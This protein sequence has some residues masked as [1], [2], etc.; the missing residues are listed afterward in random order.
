MISNHIEDAIQA[1]PQAPQI[2]AARQADVLANAFDV[3]KSSPP[4]TA[5][6]ATADYI[7]SHAFW[8]AHQMPKIPMVPH[9][10]PFL[11]GLPA[12]STGSKGISNIL[13]ARSTEAAQRALTGTQATPNLNP[14]ARDAMRQ[15]LFGGTLSQ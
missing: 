9:A 1:H 15:L 5:G 14:S 3:A 7:H 12:L 2:N 10:I 8:L 6:Q 4:G 11:L 13:G